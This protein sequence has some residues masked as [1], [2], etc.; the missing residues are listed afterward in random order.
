MNSDEPTEN[1]TAALFRSTEDFRVSQLFFFFFLHYTTNTFAFP[2]IKCK[3]I[4]F[5]PLSFLQG[6]LNVT[7]ALG[8]HG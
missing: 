1:Q 7:A 6:L 2:A 4:F 8:F 5:F 3:Y